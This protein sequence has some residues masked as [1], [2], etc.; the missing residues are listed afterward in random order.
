M[1]VC[2]DKFRIS[3]LRHREE[4]DADDDDTQNGPIYFV[5]ISL[6][7]PITAC[8]CVDSRAASFHFPNILFPQMFTA[9]VKVRIV[10]KIP[11]VL[12]GVISNVPFEAIT[13][14]A[15]IN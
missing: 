11:Y 15:E 4:N 13:A 14:A 1:K 5:I 8:I 3:F 7:L 10:M 12:A 6:G 9:V 2:K